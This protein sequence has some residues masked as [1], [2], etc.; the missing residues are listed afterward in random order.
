MTT[1]PT[2]HT[3]TGPTDYR[4]NDDW[5]PGPHVTNAPI[6]AVTPIHFETPTRPAV[7]LLLA[8]PHT[9]GPR[10][11]TTAEW[12]T[13]TDWHVHPDHRQQLA[14]AIVTALTAAALPAHLHHLPDGTPC[15]LLHLRRGRHRYQQL[16]VV[17]TDTLNWAIYH[18]PTAKPTAKPW[19]NTRPD[20]APTR[21]RHLCLILGAQILPTSP[22]DAIPREPAQP[23]DHRQR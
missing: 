8:N 4:T 13:T 9:H 12:G 16:A 18:H 17:M 14:E 15:A 21:V 7:R 10:Q 11:L 3:Y 22:T 1:P 5:F 2:R 19:P 20:D 6:L 23:A